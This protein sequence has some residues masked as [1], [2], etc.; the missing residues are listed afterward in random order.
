MYIE[1]KIFGSMYILVPIETKI[2]VS[3][4]ILGFLKISMFVD[5]TFAIWH[6][7]MHRRDYAW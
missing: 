4:Y 6:D 2:V 3:M 7:M 5:I 1:T